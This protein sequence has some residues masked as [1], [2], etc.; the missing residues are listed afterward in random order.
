MCD[1][2]KRGFTLVELLVVIAI[3]ALLL[4]IMLPGLRRARELAQ[5]V[6]C[7]SNLRQWGL[8]WSTYA[9]D[10]DQKLPPGYDERIGYQ[11][12]A[13]ILGVRGYLQPGDDILLCPRAG[14]ETIYEHGG[15]F[16]AYLMGDPGDHG[17]EDWDAEVCSYGM[18][19]FASSL[20]G[21]GA[22]N[23]QGRPAQDYWETITPDRVS[24][25]NVPMMMD[26]MWRGGGPHTG[27]ADA[28]SIPSVHPDSLEYD[29]EWHVNN[30]MHH[31][32]I[33]RHRNGVNMVFL[34]MSV[35]HVPLGDMFEKRWNRRWDVNTLPQNGW[36]HEWLI[37]Y[38]PERVRGY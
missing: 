32:F 34:D 37:P 29:D 26:A 28:Y 4:T 7:R 14:T 11:R 38:A 9:N 27:N 36:D 1:S 18:N 31:F 35:D 33:P 23:P 25:N 24:L 17:M 2:K 8:M 12:G 15:V 3:I 5:A 20:Q 30:E 13:W 16:S 19:N 6:I 10:H 22:G 21:T